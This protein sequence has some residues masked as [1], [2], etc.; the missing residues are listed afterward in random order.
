MSKKKLH[1]LQVTGAMTRGGAEVMLMDIY[2]H[3]SK[4]IHFDFL[5]NYKIKEGIVKGDFDDEIIGLGGKLK[6]IGAQW[7]IG[8]ITYIKEFKK[9][10]NKTGTP[11]VV[12]IHLN[13]KCGVIALAAKIAGIKKIIAHSHAD[14]KFR[15]SFLHRLSSVVELKFQ[16]LLIALFATDYWGASNEANKSLFYKCL[17]K[18]EKIQIINN[19]V[20]VKAF[21]NVTLKQVKEFKKSINI[22]E[23]TLLL[24]NIGRVVR[25]KNVDFIIDILKELQNRKIDFRFV[26]AGRADDE[27]YLDEIFRKSKKLQ[28]SD[29]IVY[30]GNRDDVPIIVNT[31]DIFVSPALQE[32][33][34]LVAVESQAA[35]TPCVLYTGFPKSVDMNLN[36]VTFLNNFNIQH[37]VDE[38]LKFKERKDIDK[39]FIQNQISELGFDS[40]G[41]TKKIE[42]LYRS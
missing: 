6:Y 7:D 21:Q 41:N 1:V 22:N 10:C 38:I 29:K 30:L 5:I 25:H 28:V 40:I 36:L 35:G 23:D 16:K 4:E 2:K 27:L 17:V 39:V 13:A 19:A 32:G 12:H 11:D 31:F 8:L 37:W 24:G 33:F 15:G 18:G 26:F 9:I 14:L 42:K 34:G 20:D 3:I